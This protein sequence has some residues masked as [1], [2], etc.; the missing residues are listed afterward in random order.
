MS[1]EVV[2]RRRT[3]WIV[4]SSVVGLL[5]TFALQMGVTIW[6]A[7]T[8]SATTSTKLDEVQ[9]VLGRIES[10]AYTQSDAQRD[11]RRLEQKDSTID[12]RVRRLEE[13][14]DNGVRRK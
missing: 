5:F 6:W 12:D 1:E 9:R 13:A 4:L 8:Y 7:A 3:N 10:N 14:V 2:D 11:I